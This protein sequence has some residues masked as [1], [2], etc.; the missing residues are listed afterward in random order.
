M[1]TQWIHVG[2]VMRI[3]ASGKAAYV[4][5]E[6]LATVRVGNPR[7]SANNG[8]QL[9]LGMKHLLVL[10]ELTALGYR[11]ETFACFVKETPHPGDIKALR[12]RRARDN[13]KTAVLMARF[14]RRRPRFWLTDLPVLL[15]PDWV[16]GFGRR[17]VRIVR[18]AQN[19]IRRIVSR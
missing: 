19:R 3:L 10:S 15:G 6:R 13:V 1:G 5:S 4:V 17:A 11:P 9:Y 12:A 16:L 14:F 8:N 18:A 2:A 7:W